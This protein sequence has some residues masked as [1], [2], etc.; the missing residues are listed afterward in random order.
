MF[1]FLKKYCIYFG[2]FNHFRDGMECNKNII[3]LFGHVTMKKDN[4][5]I[6]LFTKNRTN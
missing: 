2:K 6:A 4:N 5:F 1:Y 3:P